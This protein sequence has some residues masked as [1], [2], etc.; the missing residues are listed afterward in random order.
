MGNVATQKSIIRNMILRCVENVTTRFMMMGMND[1]QKFALGVALR[2]GLMIFALVITGITHMMVMPTLYDWVYDTYGTEQSI[3]N[4]WYYV[5]L[6]SPMVVLAVIIYWTFQS[7]VK[8]TPQE[9]AN[10]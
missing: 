6:Y 7:T 4:E 8:L 10:V 1:D 9:I 2:I 5:G 3:S